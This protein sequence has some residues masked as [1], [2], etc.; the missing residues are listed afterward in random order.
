MMISDVCFDSV[1]A[2]ETISKA[3]RRCGNHQAMLRPKAVSM[4][5][6]CYSSETSQ[7]SHKLKI[8]IPQVAP[9]NGPRKV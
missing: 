3:A 4:M 5:R 1:I 9:P 2:S 6:P 8:T 7:T